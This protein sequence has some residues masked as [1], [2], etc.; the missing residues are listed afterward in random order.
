MSVA[1]LSGHMT[2]SQ[3]FQWIGSYPAFIVFA[4]AA[5]FEIVAYYFPWL[6]NM[7]DTISGPVAVIAGMFVAASGMIDMDPLLKWSLAIIAG[8]GAAGIFHGLTAIVRGTSTAL[9]G[10]VG[11]P[12]VATIEWAIAVILSILAIALPFVGI[13]FILAVLFWSAKKIIQKVTHPKRQQG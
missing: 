7:M 3:G 13:I 12:V 4:T 2:L 1:S 11:N 10:G 5:I 6:D 8:G 9:S